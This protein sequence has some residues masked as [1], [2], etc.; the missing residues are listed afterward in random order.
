MAINILGTSIFTCIAGAIQGK[1]TDYKDVLAALGFGAL[2]GYGFYESR[3]IVGRGDVAEGVALS[4]L[5]SSVVENVSLGE[6][7]LAYLRY[8]T[9]PLEVRLATPLAK[10]PKA[11]ISLETDPIE[12]L[13]F[14]YFCTKIDEIKFRDGLVYGIEN[15]EILTE[16]FYTNEPADTHGSTIGRFVIMERKHLDSQTV[17]RH[18]AIHV[19]QNLQYGSI[20]A[21]PGEWF[22]DTGD[23]DETKIIGVDYRLEWFA[24]G[25][26]VF[27]K[28]CFDYEDRWSEVEAFELSK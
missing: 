6:N 3:K 28:N 9:G 1:F 8:G 27:E 20:F 2:G 23:D 11:W 7:P 15:E 13:T 5:S 22:K 18:E 24:F 19:T 26:N 21:R 14:G 25:E 16:E 17:W 4:Y 12:L 10:R